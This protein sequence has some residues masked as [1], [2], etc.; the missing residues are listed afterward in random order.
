MKEQRW[1]YYGRVAEP[2][3]VLELQKDGENNYRAV[4][5]KGKCTD[6]M[7][8]RVQ[9]MFGINLQEVVPKPVDRGGRK[10][11]FWLARVFGF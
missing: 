3:G 6:D 1:I 8:K 5:L 10:S 9:V 2:A 7:K 4:V 11:K